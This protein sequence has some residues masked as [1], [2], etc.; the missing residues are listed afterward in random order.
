MPYRPLDHTADL[1]VEV[2]AG[3][4][5]ELFGESLRALTDCITE[6]ERV[7][8]RRAWPVRLAA[9]DLE[10]LLVEWLSEAL[11]LFDARDLLASGAR[12]EITAG[13]ERC[14]LEGELLGEPRDARR[15]PLKVPLKAVTYHGLEVVRAGGGWRATLIFDI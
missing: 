10:Q 13:G 12:L 4:L 9:P 11:Y 2:W 15:H 14:E 7:E 3:S 8:P 6:V 5:E 1:G